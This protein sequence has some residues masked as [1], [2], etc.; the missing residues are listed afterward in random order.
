MPTLSVSS[1]VVAGSTLTWTFASMAASRRRAITCFEAL[2]IAMITASARVAWTF[3]IS[4]SVV[5]MTWTCRSRRCRLWG[6]SSSSPTGRQVRLGSRS[7]EPSSS[8]PASPA[9][10]TMTRVAPSNCPPSS[11]RSR[12]RRQVARAQAA[13]TSVARVAPAGTLRGTHWVTRLTTKTRKPLPMA[14]AP[15]STISSR[16]AV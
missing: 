10:T 1:W 8:R 3:S 5:P 13:I 11:S 9:P 15:S 2:G 7:I 14:T 4:W 6:S 16:L 12:S